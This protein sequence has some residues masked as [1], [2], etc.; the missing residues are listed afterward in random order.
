MQNL[1]LSIVVVTGVAMLAPVLV[2]INRWFRLPVI[3]FELGFGMLIGPHTLNLVPGGAIMEFFSDFGLA[4][5]FFM[6][7]FEIDFSRLRGR[8]LTLAG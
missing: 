1:L 2:E 7:G 8:P 6:A 3:L 5:L 4:F